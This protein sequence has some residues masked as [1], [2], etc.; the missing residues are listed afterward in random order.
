MNAIQQNIPKTPAAVILKISGNSAVQ[1]IILDPNSAADS[2]VS[3]LK[4]GTL[5][6]TQNLIYFIVNFAK[7][8]V[9]LRLRLL[10]MADALLVAQ[11]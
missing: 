9:V 10:T 2:D 6:W 5:N 11:R 7:P 3:G 4:S 8:S 1:V